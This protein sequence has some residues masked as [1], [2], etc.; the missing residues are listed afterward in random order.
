MANPVQA[1]PAAA[2][3]A[4]PALRPLDRFPSKFEV[5]TGDYPAAHWLE[6][7]DFWAA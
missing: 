1:A 2:A 6:M 7:T 5:K 4:G 3:A